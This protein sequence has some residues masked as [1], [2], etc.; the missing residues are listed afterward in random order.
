MESLHQ[1]NCNELILLE[2]VL[3]RC[4]TDERV[5]TKGEKEIF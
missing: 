5:K 4:T 3:K 2:Y 1:T